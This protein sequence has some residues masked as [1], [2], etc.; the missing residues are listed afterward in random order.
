MSMKKG[1]K[2]NVRKIKIATFN[3][4]KGGGGTSTVASNPL[5]QQT[6]GP[7]T[8]IGVD[9]KTYLTASGSLDRC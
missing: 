6:T 5:C 1:R 7:L 8:I 2:L 3:E 9:C 4:I